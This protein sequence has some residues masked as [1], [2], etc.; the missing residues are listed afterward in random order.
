MPLLNVPIAI[1]LNV[2]KFLNSRD[3][4]N[5]FAL[6]KNYRIARCTHEKLRS[7]HEKCVHIC[8]YHD[9]KR[10]K[11]FSNFGKDYVSE[12]CSERE[13]HKKQMSRYISGQSFSDCVVNDDDQSAGRG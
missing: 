7:H 4:T 9:K 11:F 8:D 2:S 6:S 3:S 1:T 10:R 5:L 12:Y 13:F